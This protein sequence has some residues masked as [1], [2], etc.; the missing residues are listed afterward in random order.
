MKLLLLTLAVALGG[1][2]RDP[3]PPIVD[4]KPVV[5]V[6]EPIDPAAPLTLNDGQK[7][8]EWKITSETSDSV[9]IRHSGGM[10]KVLKR[11]LPEALQSNYPVNADLAKAEKEKEAIDSQRRQAL[12][13]KQLQQDAATKAA[14][15]RQAAQAQ[16]NAREIRAADRTDIKE[17]VRRAAKTR[18]NRFFEYEYQPTTSNR[19]LSF[20]VS[21]DADDPEPWT[22]VPGLFT[23]KGKG[24]VKFYTNSSGVEQ[25]TKDFRVKVEV[26]GTSVKSTSIDLR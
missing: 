3:A 4:T 17:I 11:A 1:C 13:A 12:Q 19:I 21:I 25:A 2:S 14:S 18:A 22:G 15:A 24:Y 6:P 23:V 8:N 16:V 9:Y 20:D 7:F 10:S 5:V 26:D